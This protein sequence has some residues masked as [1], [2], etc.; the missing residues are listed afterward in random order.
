MLT[1]LTTGYGIALLFVINFIGAIYL[2]ESLLNTVRENQWLK[3]FFII[4]PVAII[5]WIMAAVYFLCISIK[6]LFLNYF[7]N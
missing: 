6:S 4:P 1:L 2:K 3:Y 7:K 5:C